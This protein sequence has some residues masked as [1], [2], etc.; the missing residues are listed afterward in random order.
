M[1]IRRRLFF[2]LRSSAVSE[3]VSPQPTTARR[4]AAN[5][6]LCPQDVFVIISPLNYPQ[7]PRAFLSSANGDRAQGEASHGSADLVC[8]AD[9]AEFVDL[10]LCQLFQEVKFADVHSL[11]D[12]QI[13]VDRD[14]GLFLF[15]RAGAMFEPA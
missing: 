4:M 15:H 7:Y 3:P 6:P 9:V 10:V 13:A 8:R 12:Q 5:H 2:T 14:K 11:F 1:P